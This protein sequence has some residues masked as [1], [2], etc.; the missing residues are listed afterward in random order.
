V[1][2]PFCETTAEGVLKEH[3]FITF[4]DTQELSYQ[5]TLVKELGPDKQKCNESIERNASR[6]ARMFGVS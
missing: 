2:R 6:N 3:P 4:K 5:H 1:H